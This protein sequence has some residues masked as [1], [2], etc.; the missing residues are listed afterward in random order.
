M[1]VSC[2]NE[3]ISPGSAYRS[4]GGE[5]EV[6][7]R[8]VFAPGLFTIT[9]VCG[10]LSWV[11][12][13]AV[14]LEMKSV[15]G[16]SSAVTTLE[17]ALF[18]TWATSLGASLSLVVECLTP[19]ES[20]GDDW[21]RRLGPAM[22][23]APP[24]ILLFLGYMILQGC[25]LLF[26][27]ASVVCMDSYAAMV[28]GTGLLSVSFLGVT[29]NANQLFGLAFLAATLLC[30]GFMEELESS[31]DDADDGLLASSADNA[32][33]GVA[34]AAGAGLCYAGTNCIYEKVLRDESVTA[35]ALNGVITASSFVLLTAVFYP[36]CYATG[37][38]GSPAQWLTNLERM[39][40]MAILF[41]LFLLSKFAWY[42]SETLLVK[43]SGAVWAAISGVALIPLLWL[44][45][46]VA[47]Y[48]FDAYFGEPWASP[49][50][51]LQLVALVALFFGVLFF[52]GHLALFP[53]DP[54]S[55][56]QRDADPKQGAHRPLIDPKPGAN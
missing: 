10:V 39:P 43:E 52:D 34:C 38:F 5:S 23:K 24:L 41:P 12:S 55:E 44:F 31:S 7:R 13:A 40:H 27:S 25:A 45:Q 18:T 48:A 47:F 9:T 22:A 17:I 2:C 50:S 30:V 36:V 46:L 3:M 28:L 37:A 54:G 20:S 49:A 26:I 56:A 8:A 19:R 29:L 32:V 51:Y 53:T 4:V 14:V 33:L 11:M 6:D 15:I 16:A 42:S 21:A 1:F 35:L